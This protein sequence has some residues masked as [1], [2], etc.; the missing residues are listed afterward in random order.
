MWECCD[1]TPLTRICSNRPSDDVPRHD[2]TTFQDVLEISEDH[3]AAI[4]VASSGYL[5]MKECKP[6]HVSEHTS[7]RSRMS[8]GHVRDGRL[9]HILFTYMPVLYSAWHIS[10]LIQSTKMSENESRDYICPLY[11][12]LSV[13]LRV[14][15]N[16]LVNGH[17]TV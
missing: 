17:S 14:H 4:L 11:R 10:H 9:S 16:I 1:L 2:T 15:P 8:G 6:E 7:W 5:C 3:L 12:P 13:L